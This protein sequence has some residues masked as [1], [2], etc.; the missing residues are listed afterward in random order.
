M[1]TKSGPELTDGGEVLL[2]QVYPAWLSEDGEPSSQAFYPW[3]D[4]DEGCLSV[5]R[6]SLVTAA[7]AFARFTA[8][9][10]LGFGQPA[11]EVWGVRVEEAHAV[12]LTAWRDP[13]PP[14]EGYPENPS[15]ALIEFGD[16]ARNR[17]S[18][19]GKQ[20]KVCA[21]ARGRLHP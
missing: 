9:P 18:K 13:V 20:L 11:V 19:L 16:H 21:I 15:H 4:V 8:Q 14:K 12:G 6:G 5:D 2:R 17:W 1:C 10:P 7:A 3:R